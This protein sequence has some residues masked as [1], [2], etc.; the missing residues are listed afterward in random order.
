M[1]ITI[2]QP[3]HLPWLGFFDKVRQVDTF[4]ILDHVPYRKNYYQNRNKIRTHNGAVWLTIPVLTKGHFSQAI[5]DVQINTQGSPRW[6]EKCWASLAQ[7]YQRAPFW[8]DYETFFN[9]LYSKRDWNYIVDLNESIIKYMLGVLSIN[10]KV[11]K[12]S[13]ME[14]EG[15]S[16][17]LLLSIC[18]QLN[19]D[20]YLSGISG[21]NY[22]NL[23]V[24]TDA[25]I[26]VR[27]Q[28][29]HHPIYKQVYAP[30]TPCMS[31]IDLLFNYGPASLDVIRGVGVETMEHIFE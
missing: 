1:V 7:S 27:F 24:F 4:V 13:E 10:V 9:D 3:E 29:F 11:V 5:N 12:S 18:R 8:K 23:D 16:G 26:K 14:V 22:L 6:G 21:K 15:T 17:D 30:F 28:E 19:A 2:H 20:T 31:A 25:G